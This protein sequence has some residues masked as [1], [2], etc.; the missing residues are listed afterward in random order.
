[1]TVQIIG[2][3]LAFLGFVLVIKSIQIV[4]QQTVRI[5]ETLGKYSNTLEPGLVFVIPLI[6]NVVA[7]LDMRIRQVDAEVE[8]KTSDNMFVRLPVSIMMHIDPSGAAEAFYKLKDP[9]ASIRTW[10]LATLRAECS[11]MTLAQLYSDRSRLANAVQKDLKERFS[12]Y[13]YELDDVLVDQPTLSDDVQA[14]F[15]RVVTSTR[16]REAAEQEAEAKKIKIL[17]EARAESESQTLRAEGLANARRI[18]AKSLAESVEIAKGSGVSEADVLHLL[19]ET[20]R[21]DTIK[22]ASEHGKLIVMDTKSPPSLTT[23]GV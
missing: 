10:V 1:M 23:D 4:T 13:G 16:E 17:G 14:A 20:N 6:Q 12:S 21:L 5:V 2:L 9:V 8:L 3:F 19:L 18:L 22:Y 15:N 7:V 11:D